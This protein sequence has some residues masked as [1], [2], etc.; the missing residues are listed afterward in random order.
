MMPKITK[1]YFWE[2][3]S[4][5]YDSCIYWINNPEYYQVVN[6]NYYKGMEPCMK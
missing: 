2:R 4:K 6:S 3:Q 5:D 1:V